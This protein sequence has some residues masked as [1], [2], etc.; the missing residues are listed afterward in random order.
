MQEL[1]IAITITPGATFR[2]T[3]M[4]IYDLAVELRDDGPE[5]EK[6]FNEQYK[7]HPMGDLHTFAGFDQVM[8]WEK[9]FMGEEELEKYADSVGHQPK[10]DAAE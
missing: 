4:A 3:M 6:R 2:K 9:E 7:D 5:A 1:G 10:Q 8:A